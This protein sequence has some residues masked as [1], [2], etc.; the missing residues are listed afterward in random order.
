MNV[1]EDL[2]VELQEENLLESSIVDNRRRSES[3]G[4]DLDAM[5][6]RSTS[7]ELP[8]N[9]PRPTSWSIEDDDRDVAEIDDFDEVKVDGYDAHL[10]ETVAPDARAPETPRPN[11][12]AN[13]Q[14]FYRKRA[15]GEVSNLQMV[16]HVLTGVEREYMKIVPNAY[17]DFNAKKALNAFLQVAEDENSVEHQEAEF[18]LMQETESWCTAL[19]ER[20]KGVPVSN[21]R[22]YCENSRPPLSSQALV[23]LASFYRNLPF[24]EAVRSKF[25]FVITRLFS[26]PAENDLRTCLF[27]RDEILTHIN[28]LYGEWSSI[29]LYN[30]NDD[31]SDVKRAALSFEDLAIEAENAG[32]FDEL[33]DKNFF[34][35][36]RQFKGSLNEIFYAPSVAAAAIDANVRVGNAY[37]TLIGRQR[38]K[39]DVESIHSKYGALYD[40]TVA[41]GAARTLDLVD[42]LKSPLNDL[43]RTETMPEPPP[44]AE[45]VMPEPAIVYEQPKTVKMAKT[46]KE[47]KEGS[48]LF[49]NLVEKAF[50]I[51]RWLLGISLVLIVTSIGIYVYANFVITERVATS[52]TKVVDVDESLKEFVSMSR[53]SGDT[54]YALMTPAWETLPKEKR[55]EILQKLYQSGK[56]KGY[57]QVNL[58]D[59]KGKS[60][61]FA[62]ST[63]LEVV[64]P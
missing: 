14:D 64:M 30:A 21:L 2:I 60:A 46:A 27:A 5:E 49:S 13:G 3:Q 54:L 22:H 40:D 29:A 62:S 63:R 33:I 38:Q 23:A 44:V 31:E 10:H 56:E 55:Q 1:F 50:S 35:R 37:V 32:S 18:T 47:V 57:T 59:K 16:E 11:K 17:E 9:A 52:N 25:D 39:M 7:Y 34:G 28:A 12:P 24:S 20:D 15:T 41:D 4:A 26:R 48:P 53:L 19:A 61:G 42:L 43:N 51:N 6:V 8:Q 58:L 36:L 45:V